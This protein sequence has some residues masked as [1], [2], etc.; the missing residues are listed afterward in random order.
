[1]AALGD[2][3]REVVAAVVDVIQ[4]AGYEVVIIQLALGESI[5]GLAAQLGQL[6]AQYEQRGVHAFQVVTT[7][8]S[9]SRV[10]GRRSKSP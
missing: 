6:A 1:V 10:S 5:E 2:Q 7:M 4:Q 8:A 9:F 3:S